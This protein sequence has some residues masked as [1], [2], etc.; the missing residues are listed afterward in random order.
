MIARVAEA[1]NRRPG[2]RGSQ[3]KRLRSSRA[4]LA[5]LGAIFLLVL[6][7]V[8]SVAKDKNKAR[9]AKEP[10]ENIPPALWSNPLILPPAICFTVRAVRVMSPIRRSHSLK[11]TSTVSMQN[12]TSAM[13]MASS[14]RSSLVP[15]PSRR[16][17]RRVWSGLLGTSQ[18]KIT[19]CRIC[20]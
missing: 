13:K 11:R 15:R 9:H 19:S 12:L 2:T 8:P 20:E 10:P 18:T 1:E 16:P 6:A 7:A 3:A 4:R 14:G 17:Q 5:A